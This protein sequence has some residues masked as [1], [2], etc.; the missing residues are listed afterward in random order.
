MKKI[1]IAMIVVFICPDIKPNE[2]EDIY[3]ELKTL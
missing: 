3:Q 1:I 2:M